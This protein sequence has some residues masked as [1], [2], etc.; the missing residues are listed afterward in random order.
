[1]LSN[2]ALA[3]VNFYE[4]IFRLIKKLHFTTFTNTI[5]YVYF[6]ITIFIYY[7][8]NLIGPKANRT[9]F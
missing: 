2:V 4:Q 1:M 8:M 5:K 7:L 3:N 6:L 9:V